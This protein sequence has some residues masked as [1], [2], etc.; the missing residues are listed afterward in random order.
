MLSNIVSN[1]AVLNFDTP[2]DPDITN[3]NTIKTKL[4]D[5]KKNINDFTISDIENSILDIQF[6]KHNKLTD[7]IQ[8]TMNIL[9]VEK[10]I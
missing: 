2:I 4:D 6:F 8:N 9:Q 5:I 1:P 3:F 10:Y 7:E